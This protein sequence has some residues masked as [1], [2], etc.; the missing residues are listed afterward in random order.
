MKI[1]LK[2]KNYFRL[3]SFIL[4]CRIVEFKNDA[5]QQKNGKKKLFEIK[6]RK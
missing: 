3:L 1:T 5:V 6:E 4:L 2:Q